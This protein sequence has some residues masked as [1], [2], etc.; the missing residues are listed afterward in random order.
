MNADTIRP[1]HRLQIENEQQLESAF[2]EYRQGSYGAFHFF[3]ADPFPWLAVLIHA[4]VAYIHYFP[5]EDQA[6]FQSRGLAT[7]LAPEPQSFHFLQA[8]G[9]EADGFDLPAEVTVPVEIGLDVARRFFRTPSR[10]TCI[11]WEEL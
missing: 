8:G 2:Y 7:P 9:C 3:H 1:N 5:T 11:L 6:G 10:P 4:S